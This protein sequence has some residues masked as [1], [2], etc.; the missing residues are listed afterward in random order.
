MRRLGL[1]I[2]PV[3]LLFLS[4][5]GDQTMGPDPDVTPS[6]GKPDKPGKPG[7]GG[8]EDP[9]AS[10][11]F[12]SI[13]TSFHPLA[14]AFTC[15]IE[16]GDGDGVGPAYCWGYN[17]SYSLGLGGKKRG[18]KSEPSDPVDGGNLLFSDVQLGQLFA[19]GIEDPDGD[20]KGPLYCWGQN[21]H[22]ELADSTTDTR[23]D[24]A[25]VASDLEFFSLDLGTFGGC[26]L[27]GNPGS[28][29]D[30][31]CWGSWFGEGGTSAPVPTRVADN[32]Q[33]TS[34]STNFSTV[35]GIDADGDAWCW[36]YNGEGQVGNGTMTEMEW[37][38]QEVSGGHKFRALA[39]GGNITCGL[40]GVGDASGEGNL[41]CWGSRW[42]PGGEIVWESPVPELMEKGDGAGDPFVD[43]VPGFCATGASGQVYC[44]G[45][46]GFGQVGDGSYGP[47][48]SWVDQP[49]AVA[50]PGAFLSMGEKNG[51]TCGIGTDGFAYCWGANG[52]GELG[53]GTT[54]PSP[55][56]VK[57]AGQ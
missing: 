11:V 12:T 23:S 35:C 16:D 22:G 5:C 53:N 25:Q 41:L 32:L 33:F 8:G 46:N 10:L 26:A 13:E 7:G 15:A 42:E 54:Q 31:Y 50:S 4:G 56:P 45:E 55:V 2:T 36:G 30:L 43:L 37:E 49:T 40:T 9:P 38:P 44:W 28:A 48:G 1:V 17:G 47:Y 39:V 27:A 57:V 14:G 6:F 19:C 20:G 29:G 51:H 18:S 24:P 34:I 21:D 52:T 3:L